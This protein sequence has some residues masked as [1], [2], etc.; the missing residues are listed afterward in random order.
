MHI[1]HTIQCL[2]LAHNIATGTVP[3]AYQCR[4]LYGMKYFVRSAF[5]TGSEPRATVQYAYA[6]GVFFFAP[7]AHR[8]TNRVPIKF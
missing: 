3:R 1:V 5:C 7:V 6:R 4:P 8:N 2:F